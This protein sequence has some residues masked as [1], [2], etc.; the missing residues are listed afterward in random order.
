M[1]SIINSHQSVLGENNSYNQA[2]NPNLARNL[3]AL[4]EDISKYL[5]AITSLLSELS[6]EEDSKSQELY[7]YICKQSWQE[8]LSNDLQTL[9]Q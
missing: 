9:N 6:E 8:T 5:N 1:N 4:K 2:I 3:E 7:D